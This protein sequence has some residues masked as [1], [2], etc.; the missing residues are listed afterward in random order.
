MRASQSG[1]NSFFTLSDDAVRLWVNGQLLISNWTVHPLTEDSNT[2]TLAAGQ[3]YNLTLEYFNA[4]GAAGVVLSWLPPGGSKQV[5]PVTNLTPYGN[6]NPP[7]LLPI[8]DQSVSRNG[9]FTFTAHATDAD[10]PPQSLTFSLDPGAPAG[11]TVDPITGVFTWTPAAAQ[12]Y[13]PYTI[14]LRVLDDGSPVMTDAQTFTLTVL[15][16]LA[17]AAV[18]LVPTNGSWK[19]L[20]TGVNQGT[21]WRSAAFDD[22]SWKT[23][24][25][26]FGYGIGGETTLLSYGPNANNKYI[27]TYFRRTLFVPDASLVQSLAARM[28]RDDGAVVYLNDVEVWRDNMPSNAVTYSTLASSSVT[29]SNQTQFITRALS[30][31]ALV[32]G[33]NILAVELHQDSAT[34]PDARFEF[35]LTASALVPSGPQLVSVPSGNFTRL[36]WPQSAALLRVYT[37][38]NLAPP[39]VWSFLDIAPVFENGECAIRVLSTTNKTQFFRLQTP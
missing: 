17:T 25:G 27:T 30:P 1:T 11:A 38:T 28:A 35:E 13:G 7:S 23:G 9:F 33:I 5:I 34:T 26:K 18:T 29:G 37:T 21:A 15:S 14:T 2:I 10:A 20:D 4:T 16:N 36:S 39:A 31:S 3:Y 22:A 32:N 12:P 24:A 8:A 19:Y 6:N